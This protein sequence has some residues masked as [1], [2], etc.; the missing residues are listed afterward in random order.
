M[1]QR[2]PLARTGT[3]AIRPSNAPR[4]PRPLRLAKQRLISIEDSSP[5]TAARTGALG[6]MLTEQA[7]DLD[8]MLAAFGVEPT[9]TTPPERRTCRAKTRK[10]TPCRALG[11]ANGR[12]ALH[13]GASTGPRTAAGWGRTRA[14]HRKWVER[15]RTRAAGE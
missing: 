6:Q 5:L 14:G 2:P 7:G 3:P 10:G 9:R 13:G 8:R 11:L 12:C 15:G 4:P 1:T